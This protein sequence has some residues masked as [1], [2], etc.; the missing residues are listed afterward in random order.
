MYACLG[1]VSLTV[2]G[3]AAALLGSLKDQSTCDDY[4]DFLR[5][6][7][8]SKRGLSDRGFDDQHCSAPG[9][10]RT[11]YPQESYSDCQEMRL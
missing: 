6:G 3:P 9:E 2:I 11:T 4:N 1:N 10:P 7:H 8:K 5:D